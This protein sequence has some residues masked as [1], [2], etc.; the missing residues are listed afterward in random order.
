MNIVQKNSKGNNSLDYLLNTIYNLYVGINNQLSSLR[1]SNLIEF[2]WYRD[3]YSAI[4]GFFL[5]LSSLGLEDNLR[6]AFLFL[7]KDKIRLK[8]I[9][10]ISKLSKIFLLDKSKLNNNLRIEDQIKDILYNLENFCYQFGFQLDKLYI[11]K[12]KKS[13]RK[14]DRR[15]RKILKKKKAKYLSRL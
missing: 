8:Y 14:F 6:I 3:T 15:A 4:L 5:K 9:D 10:N 11:Q 1:S 12:H 2:R 13:K 7:I